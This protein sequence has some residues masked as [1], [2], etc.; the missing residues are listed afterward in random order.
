M[1]ASSLHKR[2]PQIGEIG[3]FSVGERLHPKFPCHVDPFICVPTIPA[4]VVLFSS[5]RMIAYAFGYRKVS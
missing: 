2:R 3:H 5:A 4:E 1:T